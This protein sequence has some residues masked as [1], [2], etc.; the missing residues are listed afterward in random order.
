MIFMKA[1]LIEKNQ[2]EII[3]KQLLESGHLDTGRKLIRR[4]DQLEVPVKDTAIPGLHQFTVIDQDP[5]EFYESEP[6]LRELMRS[7]LD[8]ER[9]K[10]LPGGWQMIGRV[11][12]ISLDSVLYSVKTH[13]GSAL[14]QMYPYCKSVY[15]DKGIRGD[16]RKPDRELIAQRDYVNSPQETVHIENG[17]KFK[18]DVTR[19]MFSKGNLQERIRMSTLGSGEVVVDMFAGIGY[20]TIPM[21]VHSIPKK[22]IAIEINPESYYY[23]VENTRL[24]NGEDIVEPILGDCANNTP[25]CVADRVIMGYVKHTHHYLANAILALKPSGVL[26]YH[27]TVPVHL[28]P[29][30][31]IR[32][33]RHAAEELGRG[34]EVLSWHRVKKYSPGVLHVVVDVRIL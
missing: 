7:H 17:C 9:L 28:T 32:R 1:L 19:V 22:I 11:I 30:R 27:E 34:I 20:F 33:I 12:I 25:V 23:L 26:H 3:R 31:P 15:I 29:E 5:M 6:G 8:E 24:N 4:G 10:R 18:L 21:V 16:L 13:I 2:V 14:L